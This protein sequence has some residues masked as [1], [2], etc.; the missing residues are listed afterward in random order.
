MRIITP[1]SICSNT[2]GGAKKKVGPISLM[3]CM[4]V[5][6]LSG[7]AMQKPATSACA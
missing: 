7:Q 4:A 2:R 3:S 5:S 1:V 6:A